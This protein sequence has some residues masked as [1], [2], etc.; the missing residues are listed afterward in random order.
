LRFPDGHSNCSL[1]YQMISI[2]TVTKRY[3]LGGI[4]RNQMQKMESSVGVS[5]QHSIC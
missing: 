3:L 1:K 5:K 2:L 4:F